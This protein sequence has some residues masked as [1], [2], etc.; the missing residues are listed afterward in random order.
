M[1]IPRRSAVGHAIMLAFAALVVSAP[2][3]GFA[4]LDTRYRAKPIALTISGGVS[5][6]SYEAGVNWA[7]VRVLREAR[8]N[9]VVVTGASAGNINT[10][11]TAY[12][13]CGV[14]EPQLQRPEDS[15]FW[16]VWIPVGLE[17]LVPR[18]RFE[19]GYENNEGLFTRAAFIDGIANLERLSRKPAIY[20]DCA[21]RLGI[22]LS[23]REP[24]TVDIPAGSKHLDVPAMRYVV[25]FIAAANRGQQVKFSAPTIKQID[26]WK[27]KEQ[28]LHLLPG[29]PGVEFNLEPQLR[30]YI[31]A[32]SAF[33]YAFGSMQLSFW[34]PTG[35]G[36]YAPGF[37]VF[38]DGGVFDNVPVG[39]SLRLLQEDNPPVKAPANAQGPSFIF[40]IDPD[41]RRK[42]LPPAKGVEPPLAG[43]GSVA[44]FLNGAVDSAR[45]YELQ[46][47][48]RYRLGA[49][50]IL[51]SSTSSASTELRL[52]ARSTNVFGEYYFAFGAFA[53]RRFRE[54]DFY[55][56]IFDGLM[57]AAEWDCED[58]TPLEHCVVGKVLE[59][60]R[61]LALDIQSPL[62]SYVIDR[63]LIAD[64]AAESGRNGISPQVPEIGASEGIRP[65]E[66]K[67]M[68]DVL[69]KKEYDSFSDLLTALRAAGS[70][71][72][73][74]WNSD[75]I[76]DPRGYA[77][78]YVTR[79]L[80]R[81]LTLER[82][83]GNQLSIRPLVIANLVARSV[84]P[85]TTFEL[86][87][88]TIPDG[89][90]G[91]STA[92]SIVGHMLPYYMG[93]EFLSSG[94]FG[95]RAQWRPTQPFGSRVRLIFPAEASWLGGSRGFRF[96]AGAGAKFVLLPSIGMSADLVLGG[97]VWARDVNAWLQPGS[98][99]FKVDTSGQ[100][101]LTIFE[102][103]RV[104]Y[105]YYPGPK[106]H[107]V[108]LG[109]VDFNGLSYWLGRAAAGI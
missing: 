51:S 101:G 59:M 5:L 79:L 89:K 67:A 83:N 39:L 35:E 37:G 107:T 19:T 98:H 31:L 106:L 56:G 27:I 46:T 58:Q 63:L 13:W 71:N 72:N 70:Q 74:Q 24:G 94:E 68:L 25:P 97:G 73:L 99:L 62:A 64:Y 3:T 6:G 44:S 34:A 4:E 87:P 54:M 96:G 57:S 69:T 18:K 65:V 10:L 86:D 47:V 45:K 11:V 91:F 108:S 15:L 42:L 61:A 105:T 8:A 60:K 84:I 81:A 100:A 1:W 7:L 85:Q 66:V 40:Y 103:F 17:D 82:Q 33:P 43:L 12:S 23:K 53:D 49:A 22:T 2:R 75:V 104:G 9:L 48:S 88:S 95:L 80:L 92:G 36:K 29:A 21:L 102:S 32:A 55:L 77:A 93:F 38:L 28:G 76:D 52:T 30:D 78:E 14:D 50:P 20:D 90:D 41:Q 109:L 26:D 16:K